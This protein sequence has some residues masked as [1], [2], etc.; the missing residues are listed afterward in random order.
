MEQLNQLFALFVAFLAEMKKLHVWLVRYRV[1]S[2]IVVFFSIWLTFDT[3]IFYKA[4]YNELKGVE[5]N[6]GVGLF[7]LTAVGLL[8]FAMD[9]VRKKHEGHEE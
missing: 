4:H 7:L 3:W 9:N 2:I 1:L 5:G 6:T 8:K